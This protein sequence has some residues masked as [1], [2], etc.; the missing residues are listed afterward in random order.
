VYPFFLFLLLVFQHVKAVLYVRAA[1]SCRW[2]YIFV[3][4]VDF[5]VIAVRCLRLSVSVVEEG[6]R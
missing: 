5:V 1:G 3:Y 4:G 2:S 6:E